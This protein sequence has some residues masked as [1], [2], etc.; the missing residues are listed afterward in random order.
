[1]LS[2]SVF[3]SIEREFM[4]LSKKLKSVAVTSAAF[5]AISTSPAFAGSINGGGSSFADPLMQDARQ[6]HLV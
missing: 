5:L 4:K 3:D 1:M 6:M 2:Q